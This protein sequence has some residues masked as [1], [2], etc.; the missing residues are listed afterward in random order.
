[1]E[2]AGLLPGSEMIELGRGLGEAAGA[3]KSR[4]RREA[5]SGVFAG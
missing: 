1:M 3:K 2:A 5:E 4:P